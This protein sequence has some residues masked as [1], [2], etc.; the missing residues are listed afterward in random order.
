MLVGA[1]VI[2]VSILVMIDAWAV[3]D[4]KLATDNAARQAARAYVLAPSQATAAASASQAAVAAMAASGRDPA[5]ASVT[6]AG[7]L[8]RCASISVS[9]AYPVQLLPVPL[10]GRQ[11]ATMLVRSVRRE[12]V[13]PFRNGAAGQVPVNGCG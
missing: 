11:A 1:L 2:V 7:T 6:I 13:S 5:R 8:R 4:A 3:I 9:V 12:W 10:L